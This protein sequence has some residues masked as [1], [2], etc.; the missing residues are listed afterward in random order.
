LQPT[1]QPQP[2]PQPEPAPPQ[3]APQ[4]A[5]APQPSATPVPQGRTTPEQAEA[6]RL[7]GEGLQALQK[8][9]F[10]TAT[11]KLQQALQSD[12]SN[13]LAHP[14]LGFLAFRNGELDKAAPFLQKAVDAGQNPLALLVLGRMSELQGDSAKALDFYTRAAAAGVASPTAQTDGGLAISA[15]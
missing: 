3:P 7:V 15:H 12:P 11:D 6:N 13:I 9:D 10:Q 5:P 14:S 1:P 8:G 4:P 2:A